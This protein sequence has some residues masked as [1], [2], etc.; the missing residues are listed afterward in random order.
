[1]ESAKKITVYVPEQLLQKAQAATGEGITPTVRQ[2]LELIAAGPACEKLQKLKG[3]VTFSVD[4]DKLRED[5]L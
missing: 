5:R 3:K 2:G 4:L 1:M